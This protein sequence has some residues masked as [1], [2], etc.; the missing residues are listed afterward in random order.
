M[1]CEKYQLKKKKG[2]EKETV[3]YEKKDHFFL[4]E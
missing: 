1:T 3:N 2:K 4:F